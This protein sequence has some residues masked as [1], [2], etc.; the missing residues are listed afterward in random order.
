MG[1]E[2]GTTLELS[3][4]DPAPGGGHDSRI[5]RQIE[6]VHARQGVDA[7]EVF[8]GGQI[9]IAG[10]ADPLDPGATNQRLIRSEP[11]GRRERIRQR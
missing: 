2:R 4:G 6:T 7:G 10:T 5:S 3:P 8:D 9:L 1:P 11:T